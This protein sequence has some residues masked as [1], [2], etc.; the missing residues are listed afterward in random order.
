MKPVRIS[1]I[2]AAV[3]L[4]L[5]I[6]VFLTRNTASGKEIKGQGFAVLELFTSEGC[7]SCPPADALLARIQEE[8]GNKPIYILAY[9]VDYWDHL[10]WKDSFSSS[11]F[12][13][14]QYQYS[15][16]LP[17]QVYTP[18]LVVNG[19][20]EFIG[21]DESAVTGA[22]RNAL[23][24]SADVALNVHGQLRAGK[25]DLDY[26][27]TGNSNKSKLMVAVV[28]KHAVSNVK[29]GENEGRTLSHVQIVRA[30]HEFEFGNNRQQISLPEGFNTQG[31]EVIAWVQNRN[32]GAITAA[33]HVTL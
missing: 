19:Q 14:R 15:Q 21:S 29:R 17:A 7:S 31:W 13:K 3:V 5:F 16:Q 33:T 27:V 25:L 22:I 9:H 20:R 8:A 10:G 32:T 11:R 23:N 12:S 18:Q 2:S 6:A 30:L 1:A 24:G 4:S 26:Q 28:E